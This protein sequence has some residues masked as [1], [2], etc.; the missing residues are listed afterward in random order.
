MKSRIRIAAFAAT[1][2]IRPSRTTESDSELGPL[3]QAVS[4]GR[5]TVFP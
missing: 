2:Q 3:R 4:L 1:D 5:S